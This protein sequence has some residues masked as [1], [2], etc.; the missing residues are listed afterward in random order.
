MIVSRWWVID[1]ALV[2]VPH[3]SSLAL[4]L[5]PFL[6]SLALVLVPLLSSLALVLGHSVLAICRMMSYNQMRRQRQTR[7]REVW[8]D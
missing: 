1:L 6:S 5:V 3:H 2:L 8:L 4:V 7:E